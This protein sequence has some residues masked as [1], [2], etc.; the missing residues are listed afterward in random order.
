[1]ALLLIYLFLAVFVSFTCSI[2]EAVLLTTPLSFVAIK[3][4]EGSRGATLFR[5]QKESIDRPLSAILSLNTMAHTIGAAGVGA[6]ATLIF[7]EV[8]FGLISTILTVIILLFSEIL[9]K[10]IGAHYWKS[11]VPFTGYTIRVMVYITYPF[12]VISD[13][14][15]KVIAPSQ[16]G[17]TIGSREELSAMVEIGTKEGVIDLAESR[18][19]QNIIKLSDVKAEEVMT[20]RVVVQSACEEMT[21]AEFHKVESY[22]SFT[23]IPLYSAANKEEITGFVHRQ[24]VIENMANDNFDIK[25]SSIKRPLIVAPNI[26]PLTVLWDRLLEQ[27]VHIAIIVDEYGGVEGIVTLEDIIETILGLEIMDERDITADMQQYARDRWEQ[28][29]KIIR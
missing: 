24:D 27:K 19:I 4:A 16:K 7:G 3:E 29:K 5:E 8:Y 6:Q 17:E 9:P 1:M 21:I 23:R 25:L 14:I 11:L 13:L 15:T 18:I 28:R 26:Q 20:P 2:L 10:S 22:R 12:V